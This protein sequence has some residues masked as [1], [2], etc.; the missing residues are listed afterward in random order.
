[1]IV[2]TFHTVLH[3]TSTLQIQIIKHVGDVKLSEYIRCYS[4]WHRNLF[5]IGNPGLSHHSCIVQII[6]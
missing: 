2:G 4:H 5:N 3:Y 1:M 6:F